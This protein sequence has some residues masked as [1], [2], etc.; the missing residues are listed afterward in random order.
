MHNFTNRKL[1]LSFAETWIW[2]RDRNL[3]RNLRNADDLYV[4]P[5]NYASLKRMQLYSFPKLWNDHPVYKNN[6]SLSIFL[7]QT[8]NEMLAALVG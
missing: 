2:N 5:H 1:P 8:K 6:P 7:K 4:P 3:G